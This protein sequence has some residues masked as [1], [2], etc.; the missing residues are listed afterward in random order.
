VRNQ[1]TM[2]IKDLSHTYNEHTIFN[3]VNWT[4]SSGSIYVLLGESGAG[5]TTLLNIIANM[6]TSTSGEIL[7]FDELNTKREISYKSD[8]GYL[9]EYP[10]LYPFMTPIEM[11]DIVGALK[12]V[13]EDALKDMTDKWFTVFDLH[14]YKDKVIDELS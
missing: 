10:Y 3:K 2:Q 5:K 12:G 4:L 11:I 6:L 8:L 14:K 9:T 7:F 13:D 1:F